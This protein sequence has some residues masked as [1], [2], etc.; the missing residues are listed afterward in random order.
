MEMHAQIMVRLK[1]NNKKSHM[2]NGRDTVLLGDQGLCEIVIS[3]GAAV[4]SVN[5]RY[6]HSA[7][8]PLQKNRGVFKELKPVF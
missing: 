5:P 3:G 4:H 2:I 1:C 6:R 8:L 7:S